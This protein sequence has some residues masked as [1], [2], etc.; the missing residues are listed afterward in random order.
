MG[1]ITS[2]VKSKKFGCYWKSMFLSSMCY[3]TKLTACKK[4]TLIK[5]KYKIWYYSFENI[6]PCKFCRDYIK[7]VLRP[8]YPLD[9]SGRKELMYSI[10]IWKD[11]VNKKLI[12]QGHNIQPSPPFDYIY[13]YYENNYRAKSCIEKIGVCK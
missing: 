11:Q 9:F 5:K 6:L 1:E 13:N 4:D 3:P 12:S 7:N 2:G 10:Y 8:K